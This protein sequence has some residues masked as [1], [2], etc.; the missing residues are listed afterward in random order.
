M[1]TIK[2]LSGYFSLSIALFLASHTY[3]IDLVNLSGTTG[4]LQQGLQALQADEAATAAEPKPVPETSL[5]ELLMQQLGV[6]QQQAEGGAG[7]LFQLAKTRMSA[8]NFTALSNSVPEMQ[9][10]LAAAPAVAPIGGGGMAATFLQLDLAPEMV[11][12][13]IPIMVQYVQ[14]SSRSTVAAAFQSALMGGM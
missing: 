1:K 3:A 10:M 14:N 9:A 13:F 6:T 11:Q 4:T 7:A 2:L 8:G 12:K 5:T